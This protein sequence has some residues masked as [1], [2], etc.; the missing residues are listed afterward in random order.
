MAK[1]V[2]NSQ[3]L[4]EDEARAWD[5]GVLEDLK[6]SVIDIPLNFEMMN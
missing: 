6:R 5:Q 1:H 2:S 3:S 4:L